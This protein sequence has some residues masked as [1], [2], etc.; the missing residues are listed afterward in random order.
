MHAARILFAVVFLEAATTGVSAS[1][2]GSPVGTCGRKDLPASHVS[3]PASDS[4]SR[5]PGLRTGETIE[6]TPESGVQVSNCIPFGHN[7]GPDTGFMG[8]IYRDVPAFELLPGDRIS[9]DLGALNDVEIR[10]NVYFATANVNPGPAIHNGYIITTS[11]G[12]RAASGWTHVVPDTQIPANPLGNT[13][14]GDYEL[15][16]TSVVSFSFPGGGLLV[17]VGSAPPGSYQDFGCE[18]V[19]VVTTADDV[20]GN[21]YCRFYRHLDQTLEVLDVPNSDHYG[22]VLE[23]AGS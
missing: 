23:L 1:E 13:V 5:G 6:V 7:T 8:F 11:Q 2:V 20:S 18:Q 16:Y 19:L 21:F 10:R 14:I 4:Q 12:I 15:T 9:F 17:G 22:D 3:V